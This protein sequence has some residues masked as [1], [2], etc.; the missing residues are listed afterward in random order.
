MG[1]A[2]SP[3]L[4]CFPHAGGTSVEVR[5]W[6]GR[7]GR[8]RVAPVSYP[9]RERRLSQPFLRSV[10][11]LAGFA[12]ALVPEGE[13][14]LFGHSLGAFVAYEVAH[15]L[16]ASGR[17]PRALIAAA[18]VPPRAG[19]SRR[20]I[21][22]MQDEELLG[23]LRALGGL[24][25]ELEASTELVDLLLPRIR[26]DLQAAETYRPARRPPL[27]IPLQVLVGRHDVT[28]PLEV[29]DGWHAETTAGVRIE[30]LDGSHF[31]TRE[32]PDDVI[33]RVAGFLADR[34][35]G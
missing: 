29:L 14:A 16:C 24:D 32:H 6:I 31:F 1:P 28:V 13:F 12:E 15:R 27:D 17:R 26:A 23:E 19:R 18:Q 10:E 33:R 34:D 22:V 11:A 30:V 25:D 9:G 20:A 5:S 8:W 2:A 4:L 7:L 3:T 35:A 21:H